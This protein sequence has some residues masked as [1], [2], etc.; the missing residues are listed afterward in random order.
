MFVTSP[1]APLKVWLTSV[2]LST[3]STVEG[4]PKYLIVFIHFL[5]PARRDRQRERGSKG[6]REGERKRRG[7][8]ERREATREKGKE[9]YVEEERAEGE[10]E[11]EGKGPLFGITAETSLEPLAVPSLE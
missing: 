8:A 9:E 6:G 10:K 3:P 7:E 1:S 2:R 11:R 5:C 4:L